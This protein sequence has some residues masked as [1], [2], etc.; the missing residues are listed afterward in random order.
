M[1]P[2]ILIGHVPKKVMSGT[3][4]SVICKAMQLLGILKSGGWNIICQRRQLAIP[5]C[6]LFA[7][8]LISTAA[9]RADQ[10]G[11]FTYS[12]DG[13]NVT[14]TGYTGSNGVVTIPDTIDGLPVTGVGEA[15]F[16]VSNITNVLIPDGVTSIGDY[17]FYYCTRLTGV[18]IPNSVTNIGES[19]FYGCSGL[20][21]LA[22]PGG[23]TAIG[24]SAFSGCTYLNG[25][26]I[27]DGVTT[28]GGGAFYYCT[29]LGSITIPN[30]VTINAAN[31]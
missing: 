16:H 4:Q 17:A 31:R 23:L 5:G 12:S 10:F 19:A 3:G 2:S 22:M 7:L 25:I 24:G 1:S 20:T 8:L 13:T 30:N 27:P 15:A 11:D 6:L 14:I 26:T 28:I 18:T 21:S 29:H 9:A